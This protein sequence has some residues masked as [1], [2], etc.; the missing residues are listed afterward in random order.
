[1]RKN[2]ITDPY[3]LLKNLT[4]GE[5]I[6]ESRWAEIIRELPIENDLKQALLTLSPKKYIGI[7]PQIVDLT[8]EKIETQ[9]A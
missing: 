6:S 2:G 5:R 3:S 7:A 9:R 8:L 1:M 4:R